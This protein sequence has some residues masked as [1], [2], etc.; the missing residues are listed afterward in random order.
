MV[1][2]LCSFT[3]RP[4]AHPKERKRQVKLGWENNGEVMKR[5]KSSANKAHL[6]ICQ[7]QST[8]WI[9]GSDLIANARVL[10]MIANIWGER[11]HPCLVPLAIERG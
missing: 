6:W 1:T 10:I 9:F 8:P 4:D 7:S 11:G 3:W 5:S 2:N